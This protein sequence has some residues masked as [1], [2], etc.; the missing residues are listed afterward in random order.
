MEVNISPQR[1]TYEPFFSVRRPASLMI[2]LRI[3]ILLVH[4]AGEV[5]QWFKAPGKWSLLRSAAVSGSIALINVF[6]RTRRYLF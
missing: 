4:M 1:G 2:C 5:L 3:G 6:V